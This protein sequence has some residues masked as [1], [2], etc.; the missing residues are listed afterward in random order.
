MCIPANET[1]PGSRNI[2]EAEKTQKSA[3]GKHNLGVGMPIAVGLS[4]FWWLFV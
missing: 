4:V 3:A 1:Q 2:T